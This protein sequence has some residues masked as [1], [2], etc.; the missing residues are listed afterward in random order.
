MRHKDMV[1]LAIVRW[2]WVGALGF[3]AI[4]GIKNFLFISCR[5][6]STPELQNAQQ[7]QTNTSHPAQPISIPVPQLA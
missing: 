3:Y 7:H 2:D 6:L 4:L 5:A 1:R